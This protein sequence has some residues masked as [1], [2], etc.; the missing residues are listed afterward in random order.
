VKAV[1]AKLG[2]YFGLQIG[3]VFG[4]SIYYFETVVPLFIFVTVSVVLDYITGVLAGR[5][6]K[7]GLQSKTAVKG[8]YKKAGFMC[9]F[10]LGFF[11][12]AAIPFFVNAGLNITV[13]FSTPF[14]VIIAAWIVITESISVVENL[15]GMGVQIP[16][17]L[18]KVLKSTRKKIDDE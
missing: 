18:L 13:P 1:T 9:L 2:A 15:A 11:I 5:K 6:T 4:A 17:W 16:R 8:L 3:T 12:D 7:D 14:G 10:C